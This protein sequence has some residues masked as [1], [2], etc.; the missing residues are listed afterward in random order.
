[1]AMIRPARPT[2]A[3]TTGEI[4]HQ[5]SQDNDW[6]PELHTLAE[7]ISFCGTMIDRG[8][9]TVAEVGGQVEGF[10]ARDRQEICSLYLSHKGRRRG[11][12]PQLLAKAKSACPRLELKTFEANHGAQR[13]YRREG[14]VESARSGGAGNDE[15]LPDVTYVWIKADRKE[16]Y[17]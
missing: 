1:M 16:P 12:G 14:F 4:L 8:W 10:M 5:F 11:I 3:G 6:M 13:F 15:N 9:V 17:V 2:D 7:T